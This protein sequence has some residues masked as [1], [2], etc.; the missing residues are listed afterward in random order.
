MRR[1]TILL[2]ILAGFSM[3]AQVGILTTSPT[4]ILDV[5][6]D[7]RVRVLSD[8]L[9]P[10]VSQVLV[11]DTSGLLQQATPIDVLYSSGLYTRSSSND[12]WSGIYV[13]S[14]ACRLDF[15]G[16]VDYY[17]IDFT[18]SVLYKIGTG[19]QVISQNVVTVTPNDATSFNVSWGGINYL[20][21]FTL[22]GN[23]ASVNVTKTIGGG[24]WSQGTFRSIP[25]MD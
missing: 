22:S 1:L 8:I 25:I 9:M 13:G 6:G 16:R 18:F 4:R 7:A 2:L 14:K 23:T 10:N 24:G 11:T 5:N 20:F 15:T 19:F 17:A 21:R 3:D 12:N